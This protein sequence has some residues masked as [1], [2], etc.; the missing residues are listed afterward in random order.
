MTGQLSHVPPGAQQSERTSLVGAVAGLSMLITLLVTA[1]AWPS[2]HVAP[3]DVPLAV[4]A[5]VP[6]AHR[7]DR[8]L[9]AAAPGA[10]DLRTVSTRTAATG[11]IRDHEVYG[12]IVVG[13]HGPTVLTASAASPAV[14]QLLQQLAAGLEPAKT[15]PTVT[16]VVPSP[17]DDPHG[18]T[19]AAGSLPLVLG[20]LATA[21]VLSL[22]LRR[23]TAQVAGALSVSA[24][25]GLGVG[26]VLQPW[27]GALSGSYWANSAVV[28]LGLAAVSLFVIGLKDLL[29]YAG[30]AVGALA[31]VLLSLP[32]SALLTAPEL[33]PSGWGT[34]GQLMPLGAVGSALRSAA[35]FGGNGV[36][37]P[38]VVLTGW[39]VAGLV[40]VLLGRR[41]R[42]PWD[43]EPPGATPE[44]ARHA[45]SA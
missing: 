11:L 37:R 22:R 5:P 14:A 3:R 18:A 19:F 7:L 28:A 30:L 40:L 17:A 44:P 9:D 33:L 4:A 43:G 32:L 25:A 38:L 35:F 23:R 12:A 10:F 34:L 2:A 29:G 13:P 20:G 45:V 24:L 41:T 21:A 16:D 8:R 27:L 26:A 31:M 15:A 36:G 42:Q 39:A 1:F 6:V